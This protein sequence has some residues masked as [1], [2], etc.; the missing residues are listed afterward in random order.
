M[1]FKFDLDYIHRARQ[2]VAMVTAN[3]VL[4][5]SRVLKTAHTLNKLGYRVCLY[6]VN[7]EDAATRI[8]G[9]PFEIVLMPHPRFE[10]ERLGKWSASGIEDMNYDD[11]ISIFSRHLQDDFRRKP[12]DFLHTHG[13]A[14]L[15]V[16]G[17]LYGLGEKRAFGWIHDVHEYVRGL[18]F[19]AESTKAFF[20]RV[21]EEFIHCP[22]VLTSGSSALSDILQDFYS[23]K[24][25]HAVVLNA[26][27]W[28]DFDPYYPKDVRTALD[29]PQNAPLLVYAG[30]LKPTR[31]VYALVEALSL[32]PE[33]HLAIVTNSSKRFVEDL[34]RTARETGVKGR[35]HFHPSVP[36]Y[37]ITSFF[38]TATV[39]IYSPQ[40][41]QNTETALPSELFE[42]MHAGMPSIVSSNPAIEEFV[43]QNDCGLAFEA[44][45]ARSLAETVNHVL[46]R[47]QSEPSWRQSIQALSEQYCWEEQEPV[48]AD[49]YD[50]L[51]PRESGNSDSLHKEKNY[52]V[53]YLPNTGGGGQTIRLV[54][55]MKER[56]VP[57]SSLTVRR[58]RYG[59]QPDICLE[60]G[61]PNNLD[62]TKQILNE[63]IEEYDVFHFMGQPLL[64]YY[65]YPYPTGMD[66]ILLRAAGKKVFYHVRGFEGRLASVFR[67]WSPYHYLNDNPEIIVSHYKEK[68]VRIFIEFATGVCNGVFVTD[69][70]LQTSIP[71]ALIVPRVVDLKEWAFVGI[72]PSDVLRVV[73]APSRRVVKGTKYV[74]STVEKLKSEGIPIELRLVEDTP[75][76]EV[77]K[78]YEWADVL[79]DQLRIGWYGV[80]AVEVMALGKAVVCYIRDDLKHYLPHPLPLAT[81]NPD[82]L[83]HVLKDLALDPEKVRSLGLRGR[84]YVEEF[85]D[86]EKVTATLLQIYES[87]GNPFDI[88]KAAGLFSFQR[89]EKQLTHKISIRLST[90]RRLNR[91]NIAAFF[92]VLRREG[93]RVAVRKTCEA[94][95][96]RR[97]KEKPASLRR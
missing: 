21:E 92:R 41:Q 20:C 96:F 62:A 42:Y 18:D 33:A 44:G 24:T 77:R 31:G 75:H 5:D 60:R 16:G 87:E 37:N 14:G 28:S 65:G 1:H 59:H 22:D 91:N 27:R 83:Y 11:F 49:I 17:K 97:V 78:L 82:N 10:M 73:H 69:Q 15:A 57:A 25:K 93:V 90:L 76:A 70:E 19:I 85:H 94:L 81:A 88:E 71:Q 66:W 32:L 50:A 53:L 67:R 45:N 2:R 12:P 55:A 84:K 26:P 40:P 30:S 36:F 4:Q 58:V 9:Y 23:L 56:G 63:L 6:G 29:I 3:D 64:F 86:P 7:N 35:I 43:S 54:S 79:V 48:I 47:L 8:E 34:K 52:R 51:A 95:F 39:G 74:L 13:M 80:L 68:E 46:D 38:R 89:G 72:E 61:V